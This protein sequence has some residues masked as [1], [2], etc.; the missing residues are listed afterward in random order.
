MFDPQ[1][2]LYKLVEQFNRHAVQEITFQLSQIT[3]ILDRHHRETHSAIEDMSQQVRL[4]RQ[5]TSENARRTSDLI[6]RIAAGTSA[7]H[8]IGF[9]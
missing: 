7:P 5:E 9:L 6:E 1:D 3:T 4:L 2:E 8:F